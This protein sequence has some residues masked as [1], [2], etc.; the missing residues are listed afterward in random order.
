[1][2]SFKLNFVVVFGGLD[3][4]ITATT[5]SSVQIHEKVNDN[6]EINVSYEG[7]STTNENLY[8]D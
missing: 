8:D 4:N 1:M 7:N 2:K 3:V 6:R 5:N